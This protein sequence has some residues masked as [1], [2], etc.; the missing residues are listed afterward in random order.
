MYE[1]LNS[2]LNILGKSY[3]S[4]LYGFWQVS[5]TWIFLC[6]CYLLWL[7]EECCF[8]PLI[9]WNRPIFSLLLFLLKITRQ[10][11]LTMYFSESSVTILFMIESELTC[12]VLVLWIWDWVTFQVFYK[13]VVYIHC[14]AFLYF[15]CSNRVCSVAFEDVWAMCEWSEDVWVKL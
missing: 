2:R 14:K 13:L 1:L 8:V 11:F 12:L 15:W 9:L 4:W 7:T 5:A 10:V 3:V 6:C